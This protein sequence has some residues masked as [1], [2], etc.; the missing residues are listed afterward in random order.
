M[1]SGLLFFGAT[2]LI[3]IEKRSK[4]GI[5]IL[6]IMYLK[7]ITFLILGLPV[8]CFPQEHKMAK[9]FIKDPSA[10]SKDF[11]DCLREIENQQF[12]LIDSLLIINSIDTAFIPS[13]KDDTLDFASENN[14]LKL[15]QINYSTIKYLLVTTRHQFEGFASINCTFYLGAESDTDA[16]GDSYFCDEFID[17]NSSDIV[18]LRVG[19]EYCNIL[20]GDVIPPPLKYKSK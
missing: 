6:N 5:T 8:L 18:I 14:T 13:L 1:H 7:L 9:L 11:I 20:V 16:N 19:D 4:F 3:R 2:G 12:Y 17:N 10:Y 15:S